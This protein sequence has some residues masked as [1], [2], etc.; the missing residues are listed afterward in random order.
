MYVTGLL[1]I[2]RAKPSLVPITCCR[3]KPSENLLLLAT[4]S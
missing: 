3:V 1:S 2:E 4:S